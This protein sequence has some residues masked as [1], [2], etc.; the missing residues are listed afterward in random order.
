MQPK[1]ILS[2][3]PAANEHDPYY[4]RYIDLVPEGDIV[5]TLE[6]QIAETTAL[7]AGLSEERAGSTYESGKW[8]IK[9]VLGHLSDTERIL[10]YRALRISRN[11]QV[12]IEGFDQDPYVQNAPFA[13]CPLSA[14]LE[15]F[16]AVRQAT[17][18]LFRH[19]DPPAWTRRGIANEKEITV[20]ALAYI[21]AGHELHHRTILKQRYPIA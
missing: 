9:E 10:S 2:G 21:I 12:P 1:P 13:H 15:E 6:T 5:T 16:R 8:T 19:L 7:L 3:R 20:R 18:F 4:F 17:L 11:D 14:I